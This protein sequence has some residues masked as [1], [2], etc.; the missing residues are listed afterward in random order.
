[1]AEKPADL[2]KLIEHLGDALKIARRTRMK[3]TE[4]LLQMALLDVAQFIQG[5]DGPKP[6]A[7]A[8][9]SDA[10]SVQP[11][12]VAHLKT[13]ACRIYRTPASFE[14][15][16]RISLLEGALL[17]HNRSVNIFANFG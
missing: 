3:M 7:G 9:C 1:M 12:R 17:Y 6:P 15:R 8:G 16:L 10:N 2:D 5:T 14:R 4:H 11:H 13:R